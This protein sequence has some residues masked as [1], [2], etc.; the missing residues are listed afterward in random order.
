VAT[1][2]IFL[3]H[4]KKQ[5]KKEIKRKIISEVDKSELVLLKFTEEEKNS[6]LTWEHSKEFEYKGEMYDI[7][8]T[9]KVGDTAYYWCWWDHEETKLNKQLNHLVSLAMG[10]NP[11]NQDNQQRLMNF[12]K[13]LYFSA[14]TINESIVFI[15]IDNKCHLGDKFYHSVSLSPPPPPPK[16]C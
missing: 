9:Y 4:Q 8:E 10:S 5:I 1:T 2:F 12:F 11:K 13:S 15:E 6:Q 3:K 16:N 14:S 7:I